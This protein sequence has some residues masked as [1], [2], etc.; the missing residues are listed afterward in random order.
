MKNPFCIYG[1]KFI[2][3]TSIGISLHP[4]HGEDME[5]LIKNADLAMYHSK[6]RG[7]NCYS[8]FTPLM[9]EKAIVRMSMLTK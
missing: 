5:T 9:K 3:S 4:N 1:Q 8:F 6:E 2:I 7:R